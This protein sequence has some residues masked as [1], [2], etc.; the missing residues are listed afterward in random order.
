MWYQEEPG[1]YG[2]EIL[3]KSSLFGMIQRTW[4][5]EKVMGIWAQEW[6]VGVLEGET[7]GGIFTLLGTLKSGEGSFL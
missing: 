6:A 4:A 7:R 1:F 5:G 2:T 3:G